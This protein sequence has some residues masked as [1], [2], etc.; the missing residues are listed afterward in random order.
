MNPESP[1]E[2]ARLALVA[3]PIGNLGDITVRAIECL[4]NADII[5]AE[6]TRRARVLL[7]HYGISTRVLRYNKDNEH[8]KTAMLIDAALSGSAVAMVTDAG[9]PCVSDPGYLLMRHAVDHG[10]EPLIIPGVSALT[11]AISACG[12]PTTSFYFAGFLTRK[13]LKRRNRLREFRAMRTTII[14]FESC[15][16]MERLLKE[17]DEEIGGTTQVAILREATK[18]FEETLRGTVG[19]LCKRLAGRRWKG[20]ITLVMSTRDVA[21]QEHSECRDGDVQHDN[22][23]SRSE[24]RSSSSSSS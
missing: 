14:L 7:N 6:D 1:T 23:S 17:I 24:S 2:T 5:A 22:H 20:E 9:T 13:S 19:I 3:T 8:R 12:L 4:K 18:K 10:I 16:R 21:G 15:H 11:F